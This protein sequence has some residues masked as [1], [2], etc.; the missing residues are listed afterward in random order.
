VEEEGA[1]EKRV[2]MLEGIALRQGN[3]GRRSWREGKG[4]R[5]ERLLKRTKYT[6]KGKRARLREGPLHSKER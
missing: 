6:G 1:P 5:R 2:S 3:R 4:K